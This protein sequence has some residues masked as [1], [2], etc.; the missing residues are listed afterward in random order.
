MQSLG[1]E[2]NIP[3][4]PSDGCPAGSKATGENDKHCCCENIDGCCWHKCPISATTEN[5]E[6]LSKCGME[7]QQ[8][9]YIKLPAN[10]NERMFVA[11]SGNDKMIVGLP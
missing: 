7:K 2:E 3:T 1:K 5:F 9:A 6:K 8:W 11:Q 10:G 4:K